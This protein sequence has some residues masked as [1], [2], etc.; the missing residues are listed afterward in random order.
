[1]YLACIRCIYV[2]GGTRVC[3]GFAEILL[4]RGLGDVWEWYSACGDTL[5]QRVV[6]MC[7]L[8]NKGSFS[9]RESRDYVVKPRSLSHI[10]G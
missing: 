10:R 4:G 5:I 6:E 8:D 2:D 3:N 9:Q 7:V 1:M